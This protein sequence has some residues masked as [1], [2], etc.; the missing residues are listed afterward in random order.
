MSVIEDENS[1]NVTHKLAKPRKRRAAVPNINKID[2]V[3]VV[4]LSN[5]H[6][7]LKCRFLFKDQKPQQIQ[8][9]IPLP[10]TQSIINRIKSRH[11]NIKSAK[12]QEA[13][14]KWICQYVRQ[15]LR[16]HWKTYKQNQLSFSVD[17]DI[18]ELD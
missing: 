6:V 5:L 11:P 8:L 17:E 2:R 9:R 10:R 16:R 1:V 3:T 4:S 18:G 12:L 14:E 15:K 13:I 7:E